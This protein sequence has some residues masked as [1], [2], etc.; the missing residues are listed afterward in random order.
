MEMIAAYI[1][2]LENVSIAD[3][4]RLVKFYTFPEV[5]WYINKKLSIDK[6]FYSEE[7]GDPHYF[8][9]NFLLS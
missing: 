6:K 3:L 8:A 9:K 4:E 7:D 5:K 1:D 2:A